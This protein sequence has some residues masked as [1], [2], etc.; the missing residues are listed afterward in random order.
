MGRKIYA[1]IDA[2]EQAIVRNCEG[3]GIPDD[4]TISILEHEFG[5]LEQSGFRLKGAFISDYDDPE[6]WA[7]YIDYVMTWAF[8]HSW[9]FDG[10]EAERIL[11]YDEWMSMEG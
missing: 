7:R 5:W 8:D 10:D 4:G 2:D 6:D 1:E 9:V 11:S 3:N